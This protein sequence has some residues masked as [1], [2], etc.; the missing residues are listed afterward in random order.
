MDAI[1]IPLHSQA[2]MHTAAD[3]LRPIWLAQLWLYPAKAVCQP[4]KGGIELSWV[5]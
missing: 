3:S 4:Q 1:L 5:G 2:N